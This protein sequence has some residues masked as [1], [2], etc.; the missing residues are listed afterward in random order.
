M[1]ALGI[2]IAVVVVVGC[3]TVGAMAG[4]EIERLLKGK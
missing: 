2:V 4:L 3:G 1:D